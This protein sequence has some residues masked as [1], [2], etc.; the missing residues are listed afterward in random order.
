M[1]ILPAIQLMSIALIAATVSIKT[2]L[3]ST[4]TDAAVDAQPQEDDASPA[5][6]PT[7]MA[8]ADTPP[9]PNKEHP[10]PAPVV[11]DPPPSD[12]ET[13]TPPTTTPAAKAGQGGQIGHTARLPTKVPPAPTAP[14]P[15]HPGDMPLPDEGPPT[16][17]LAAKP[18]KEVKIR[19]TED[20][21]ASAKAKKT[22][23]EF[24]KVAE[25]TASG[26]NKRKHLVQSNKPSAETAE[27]SH[28]N[29]PAKKK[30]VELKPSLEST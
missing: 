25:T 10:P 28:S 12:K 24:P 9:L 4:F 14:A 6:A 22:A 23:T 8:V 20:P 3:T 13:P 29:P 30:R 19:R 27:A 16:T 18:A 7:P 1:S 21:K 15:A 26:Q 17:Q 2:N 11:D 5:S